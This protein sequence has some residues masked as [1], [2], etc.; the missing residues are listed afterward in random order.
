MSGIRPSGFGAWCIC[1]KRVPSTRAPVTV[2]PSFAMV[3]YASEAGS[4]RLLRPL[5]LRQRSAVSCRRPARGRLLLQ[6]ADLLL[7]VLDLLLALGG[8]LLACG[9][10]RLVRLS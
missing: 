5:G 2:S 1:R 3:C 6:V 7:Q 9:R 8:G 4:A 10:L